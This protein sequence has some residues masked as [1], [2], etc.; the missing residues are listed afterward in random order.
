MIFTLKPYYIDYLMTKK[1]FSGKRFKEA[2]ALHFYFLLVM[3]K[4]GFFALSCAAG[5]KGIYFL[6]LRCIFSFKT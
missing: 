2:L 5:K 4:T 1:S 6:L 3:N